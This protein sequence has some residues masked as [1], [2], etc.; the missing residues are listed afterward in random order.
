MNNILT[1]VEFAELRSISK[2]YDIDKVE[3][4]ITQAHGDLREAL[5][6]AFFYDVMKNQV[7][8]K[9]TD[10]LEGS[11]F[12]KDDFILYQNGIKSLVADYAYARYLYEL[13][14]NHSPF[15][16]V[17]KNSQDS[18]PV[19]RNTIKDIVKQTNQDAARKWDLIEDYLNVSE[20]IFTVW[21]KANDKGQVDNSPNG[22]NST[23]FTF[24]SSG[25]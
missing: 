1:V 12:T 10:L 15:G 7:D 16:I 6:D 5:G 2:K 9:Y 18:S 8:A 11:E 17:N 3:Q 13:N 25:K 4:A 14:I 22:F 23:R 24:F 21:K 20:E 19:D